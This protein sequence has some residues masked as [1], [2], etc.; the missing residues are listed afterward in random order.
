[1]FQKMSTESDSLLWQ[2]SLF[3]HCSI[4]LP[5]LRQRLTPSSLPVAFIVVM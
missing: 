3:T 1:M 5:V 4:G 2:V